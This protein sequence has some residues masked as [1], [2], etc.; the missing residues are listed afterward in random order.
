MSQIREVASVKASQIR[1][2]VSVKVSQ[3]RE[4]ASVVRRQIREVASVKASDQEMLDMKRARPYTT[5]RAYSTTT[6]GDGIRD[7][8]ANTPHANLNILPFKQ[9]YYG[10]HADAFP[11]GFCWCKTEYLLRK[12]ADVVQQV[13]SKWAN[14]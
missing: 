13:R 1:E 12:L 3:I 11:G 5:S 4:V 9:Y 6:A 2:V 10:N 8:S 14:G 7:M